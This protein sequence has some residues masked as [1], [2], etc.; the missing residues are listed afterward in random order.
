MKNAS[1]VN[2][3][4]KKFKFESFPLGFS[5]GKVNHSKLENLE[6]LK[7]SLAFWRSSLASRKQPFKVFRNF[8]KL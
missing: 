3:L 7:P 4:S 1:K 8:E 2:F 5:T 6:F